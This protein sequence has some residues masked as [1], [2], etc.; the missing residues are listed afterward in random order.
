M[1]EKERACVYVCV[2]E[3]IKPIIGPDR[4]REAE[5]ESDSASVV[6]R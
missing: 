1:R 2:R 3:E 4:E 5:M 6:V